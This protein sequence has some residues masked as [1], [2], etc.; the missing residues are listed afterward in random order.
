MIN[1]NKQ[2]VLGE[3]FKF[4]MKIII[5]NKMSANEQILLPV[6]TICKAQNYQLILKIFETNCPSPG[7]AR[8]LVSKK[9]NT[10]RSKTCTNASS[11][12]CQTS[13]LHSSQSGFIQ[14]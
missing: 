6:I 9:T 2:Q 14:K 11:Q 1:Q 8:K 7:N 3:K 13:Y 12:I 5:C 10:S 4:T